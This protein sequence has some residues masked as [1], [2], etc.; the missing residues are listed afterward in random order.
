M[1]IWNFFK[2][3]RN[4]RF[5]AQASH[6]IAERSCAVVLSRVRRRAATMRIAEA[7]GYVR[8]RALEIVHR[9]LA[10]AYADRVKLDPDT[11][12]A[13]VSRATEAVVARVTA[14]LRS[15]PKTADRPGKRHA[16]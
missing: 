8:S 14:E 16:A 6:E 7:R 15:V 3:R 9:E 1:G 5:V 4:A 12:T 11:Q 10:A 13:I 2:H